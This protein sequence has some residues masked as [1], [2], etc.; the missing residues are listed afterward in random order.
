MKKTFPIID[1]SVSRC[2]LFYKKENAFTE[3]GV[4]MLFLKKVSGGEKTQLI[5]RAETTLG[6]ILLNVML[7]PALT[8]QRMGKN[9]V[10]MVSSSH[11]DLLVA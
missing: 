3:K 5:V 10:M 7:T 1:R 8:T 4:G 6:N 11:F 2:K 9:N